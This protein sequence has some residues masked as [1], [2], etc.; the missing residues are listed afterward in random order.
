MA[1]S[2]NFNFNFS[3][4]SYQERFLEPPPP[5]PYEE[6]SDEPPEFPV[7]DLREPGR[8]ELTTVS[9]EQC[10]VHL[11]LLA[12][13]ADLRDTVSSYDG[14]FQLWDSVLLN[15][16]AFRT[17]E[18][19][20]QALAKI[21]EKRWAVYTARAV[22]RFTTWWKTCVPTSGSRMTTETLST[23]AYPAVVNVDRRLTWTRDK[24]PPLGQY[25]PSLSSYPS[26]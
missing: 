17:P 5:P 24:L 7:L 9:P 23:P 16:G 22:D 26:G 21:K 3:S 13:L 4:T 20:N 14:L 12:A 18:E 8:A 15:D 10:V 11:K 25:R 6:L 2:N 19:R 1:S